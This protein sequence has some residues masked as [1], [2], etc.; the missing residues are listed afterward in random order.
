M[1]TLELAAGDN[2]HADTNLKITSNLSAPAA[3]A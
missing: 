2:S 1:A 3:V